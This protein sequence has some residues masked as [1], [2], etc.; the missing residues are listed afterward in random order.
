MSSNLLVIAGGRDGQERIALSL[1]HPRE[2]IDVTI[3]QLL[4]ITVVPDLTFAAPDGTL[5]SYAMP[6]VHVRLAPSICARLHRLT[7]AILQEKMDI[8]IAGEVVAS[9]RV[10]EPIGA[11]Q[12]ISIG[13]YDVADAEQLAEKLRRG[14]ARPALR[15]V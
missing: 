13:V 9:P 6:S 11:E 7:Q 1:V 8:V 12:H 3:A 2:R 15:A 5:R 14:W 10:L 4:A